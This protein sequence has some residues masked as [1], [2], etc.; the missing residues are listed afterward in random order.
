MH[1]QM[2]RRPLDDT[3]AENRRFNSTLQADLLSEA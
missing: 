1:D 3:G 2:M